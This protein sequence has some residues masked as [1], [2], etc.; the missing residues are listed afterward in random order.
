MPCSSQDGEHPLPSGRGP[1]PM[2]AIG[3]SKVIVTN[4]RS[5]QADLPGNCDV[6]SQG[7]FPR[8]KTPGPKVLRNA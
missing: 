4:A 5:S 2:I 6:L 1:Q 3:S 7:R 8:G